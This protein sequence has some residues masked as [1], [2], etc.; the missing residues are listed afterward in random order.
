MIKDSELLQYFRSDIQD[1][2]GKSSNDICFQMVG[3]IRLK[4]GER[5]WGDMEIQ[6]C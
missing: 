4:L 2:L 1:R 3:R 5:Y 6:N